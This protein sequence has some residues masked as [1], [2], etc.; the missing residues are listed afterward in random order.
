MDLLEI[1]E[2]LVLL[3]QTQQFKDLLDLRVF[4]V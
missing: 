4:K 3:E 1:L 2:Q